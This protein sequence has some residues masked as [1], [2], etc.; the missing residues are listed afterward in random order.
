MARAREPTEPPWNVM[1][2]IMG[3]GTVALHGD[4]G[5]RTEYAS[6]VGLF[7][8]W[9][10]STPVPDLWNGRLTKWWH[11]LLGRLLDPSTPL[12]VEPPPER[13]LALER[14]ASRYGVP[15]VSLRDAMELGLLAEWGIPQGQIEEVTTWAAAEGM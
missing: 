11:H 13:A 3:W 2:L 14:A 9:A 1:G 7:T 5:F 6:V 15:L 10:W 4:E 8:D 12:A